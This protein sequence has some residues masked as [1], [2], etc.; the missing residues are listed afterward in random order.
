MWIKRLFVTIALTLSL[1][2]GAQDTTPTPLPVFPITPG[3]YEGNINDL[4]P[5]VRYSFDMPARQV[6]VVTMTSTSGDLDAFLNLF[7]AEGELIDSNDDDLDGAG[8]DARISF[9]TASDATFVIEAT[10]FTG[11][12]TSGTYRLTLAFAGDADAEASV[13][14]LSIDPTF[15]VDAV[16]IAYD[17]FQTGALD[18]ALERQYFLLGGQQ[19]DF[20]RVV[21]TVT[22]G[23]LAPA[24]RILNADFNAISRMADTRA[25]EA[26]AYATLPETGWY[27]IEAGR[28]RGT[29]AFTLAPS[30]LSN[31]VITPGELIEGQFT[32]DTPTMAF[33]FNATIEDRIFATLMALDDDFQPELAILD[34]NLNPLAERQATGSQA[35]V[36][37]IMPRSGPYIIQVRSA[38]G[39]PD[40]AFT[41]SLRRSPLAVDKLELRPASY[42]NRYKGL[43]SDGDPIEYYRFSGKAG[44]LITA[45]MIAADA[46][47]DPYLI[48]ADSSLNELAFND[49]TG[50]TQNARIAQFELPADGD[51]LLLAT[52]AGLAAGDSAGDYDLELTV[53]RIQPL[54]GALMATLRWQG[55]ADLNLFVRAPSGQIVSW[56]NPSIPEGGTLQIDSNTGCETPTAQPIEHIYW[57]DAELENGEYTVWV[58]YQNAC[59]TSLPVDFDFTLRLHGQDVIV[60]PPDEPQQLR[61]DQRYEVRV[62]SFG[63]STVIF[64]PGTI[65]QPS[66]QQRAS[67]GG[68]TLIVYGQAL[69]GTITDE[70][71]AHFYQFAGNAGDVVSITVERLTGTLDA[72][73]VLRDYSERNLAR[74]DDDSDTDS[75]DLQAVLPED[76]RYIIAVTRYGLRDGLTTGDF[77][78]TLNRN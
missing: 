63:G 77:A 61:P 20:V 43:I 31:A 56:S 15:G 58:W 65:S 41:L 45:E 27:L 42:N 33:V 38:G 66:A 21:Q 12:L 34:L 62:R 57:P 72:V 36:R 39:R 11:R 35:R 51:Y 59:S 13:D 16:R 49:N 54:P 19:G 32:A 68:D 64:D 6:A 22:D 50:L 74:S 67:Q 37:A 18:D 1:T 3:S 60:V 9:T 14:P 40:A 29:G 73:L 71:Y 76:G 28:Q 8:R 24:L 52:R 10:R 5:S 78:L 48:L 70:A 17:E 69:N 4:L 47:L 25:G 46:E 55:D 26:V 44:E 23:D 2:V 75:A 30:R 7:T 53:G